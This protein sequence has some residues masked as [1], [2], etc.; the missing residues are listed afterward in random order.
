MP[1]ELLGRHCADDARHPPSQPWVQACLGFIY[2]NQYTALPC[3]VR[4]VGLSDLDLYYN[5]Q[6]CQQPCTE[7]C[8]HKLPYMS[9]IASAYIHEQQHNWIEIQY[10]R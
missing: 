3:T 10:N 5:V 8:L 1:P 9:D 2:E 6:T 7:G 4:D